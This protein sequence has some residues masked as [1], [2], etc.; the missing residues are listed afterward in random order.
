[1]TIMDHTETIKYHKRCA[2]QQ[3]EAVPISALGAEKNAI[4]VDAKSSHC[5]ED[6][7]DE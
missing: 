5:T 6:Y 4:V 1:M 3:E 7:M 2:T